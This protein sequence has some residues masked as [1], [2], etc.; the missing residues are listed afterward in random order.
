MQ[1]YIKYGRDKHIYGLI[2]LKYSSKIHKNYDIRSLSVDL[3]SGQ[4]MATD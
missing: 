1:D 2:L 4:S 3:L